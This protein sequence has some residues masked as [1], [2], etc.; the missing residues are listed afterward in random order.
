MRKRA[1]PILLGRIKK[2]EGKWIAYGK[3]I[4]GEYESMGIYCLGFVDAL[5]QASEITF[6]NVKYRQ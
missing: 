3:S 6:W 5:L 2:R 1:V 4:G